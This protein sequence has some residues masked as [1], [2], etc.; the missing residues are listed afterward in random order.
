MKTKKLL[1]TTVATLGLAAGTMAQNVPAYVPT[2]GLVGWWPFNG[3]ANDESGNGNNG[4]VN[5][6]T[7]TSD[8]FGSASKAYSFNGTGDFIQTQSGLDSVEALSYSGWIKTATGG[9]LISQGY[10]T[11]G[12]ELFIHKQI[13]GGIH[14]GKACFYQSISGGGFGK[15]TNNTYSDFQWHHIVGILFGYTTSNLHPDSLKIYIDGQIVIQANVTSVSGYIPSTPNHP[16]WFGGLPGLSTS[17]ISGELDDIGI[18]N[19]A[20]T[21][22]EISDLYNAVNCSNNLT[23]TPQTNLLQT[24]STANF[25][26]TTSDPNPTYVWQSDFGQGFQ[27]LNNY[28]KYSGVNTNAL[29]ISNVQLSEHNQ[30]VR[31][32]STSGNCVDTSN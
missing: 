26:A 14:A 30:P 12:F 3:N 2:N 22:Q 9:Y 21:Q 15:M 19:R 20:L 8:R 5:G 13:T 27:T 6:A 18:W 7:L 28:G 31:A 4:T 24:G 29:S 17:F 32:I 11:G 23:I 10:T 25:N 1:L 16:F